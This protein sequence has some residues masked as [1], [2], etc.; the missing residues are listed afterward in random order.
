MSVL[1][2]T[3]ATGF[4]GARFV[5]LATAQGHEVR[6]LTRRPQPARAGV[7]WVAG[8]LEAADLLAELVRGADAVVHIAGVVNAPDAAAFER[9]NVDGTRAIVAAAE[10]GGV[11]RLVHVSSL[12]SREPDLSR[13]GA[14]KAGAE[15]VIEGSALEWDMV[16]PPSIYGPGDLDQ[17]ELFRLARLGL[18]F[19]PPPGRLSLI[20]ADDLAALL[21]ALATGPATGRVFEADD[22]Q[23][24]GYSYADFARAIGRAVGRRVLPMS[25]P[26]A[27][28]RLG[29]AI[30]RG[31][32]GDKARLTAD[33]VRYFCHPDWTISPDRRPPPDLWRPAIP[34]A[35]GLAQTARWYRA[36]GL[37]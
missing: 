32:R 17:L 3:G 19:L 21:L 11:R 33:R 26:P 23:P 25:L 14:S 9:G 34:T 22:G 27:L 28:L 29:A 7:T 35:E 10:R 8:S 5:D 30:D 16:R 2:V 6:A 1:A 4:V 18:A 24:S 36:N 13:Y 12:A 37:L 20:H 31:V 15:A